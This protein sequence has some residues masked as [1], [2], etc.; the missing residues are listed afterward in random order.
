M[1]KD[2]VIFSTKNECHKKKILVD[3]DIG[4]CLVGSRTTLIDDGQINDVLC[5]TRIFYNLLSIYLITHSGES[6]AI[7]DTPNHVGIKN[8]KYIKNFL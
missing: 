1:D 8:A 5:V 6:K 2:K 4:R 3:E 7:I